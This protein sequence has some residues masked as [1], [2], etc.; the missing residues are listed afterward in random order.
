MAI[1][2]RFTDPPP[3]LNSSKKPAGRK[4]MVSTPEYNAWQQHAGHELNRQKGALPDPAFWSIMVLIPASKTGADV[5]NLV[6][7]ILDLLRK[8]ARVPDDRFV[9]DSHIKFHGGEKVI[10]TATQEDFEL[11]MPIMK[12]RVGKAT[13]KTMLRVHQQALL[14]TSSDR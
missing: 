3:S 11:W 7:A 10:V 4:G 12:T 8:H 6:K 1:E 13:A 5:D 9:V 14:Q 2:F